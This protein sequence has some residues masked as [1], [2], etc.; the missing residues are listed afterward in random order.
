MTPPSMVEDSFAEKFA[1]LL[2]GRADMATTLRLE[3]ISGSR[4][5]VVL[6]M[7]W[8][9]EVAQP[10]GVFAAA[11]LFGLADVAGTFLAMEHVT[12]GGFPLAVGSNIHL[13][14][15]T[16]SGSAIATARLLKAGRTLIRTDTSV[17]DQSGALLASVQTTYLNPQ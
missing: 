8:S 3:P 14:A 12:K 15:N 10:T 7:P 6:Q 9:A 11:A 13:V 2:R 1:E 16:R 5:E 17:V 4:D